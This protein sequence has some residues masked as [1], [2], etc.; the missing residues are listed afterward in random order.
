MFVDGSSVSPNLAISAYRPLLTVSWKESLHSVYC[1]VGYC[2]FT[3]PVY[4]SRFK[5]YIC[6]T[7]PLYEKMFRFCWNLFENIYLFN[8]IPAWKTVV[9]SVAALKSLS[10]LLLRSSFGNSRKH[11]GGLHTN[12]S[13]IISKYRRKL[14]NCYKK[15]W[16]TTCVQTH[17]FEFTFGLYW[18]WI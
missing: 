12:Q 15:F 1:L 14:F 4:L 10:Q 2:H 9:Y 6:F 7:E 11:N 8:L 13:E 18:G 17:Y 3:I 5:S 16:K